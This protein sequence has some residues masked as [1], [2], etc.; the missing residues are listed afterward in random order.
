M[1]FGASRTPAGSS[2]SPGSESTTTRSPW[3]ATNRVRFAE[4]SSASTGTADPPTLT[5]PACVS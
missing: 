5:S 2:S 1:A 4:N 3:P